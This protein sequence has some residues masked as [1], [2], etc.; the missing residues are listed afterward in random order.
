M[1]ALLGRYSERSF[2]GDEVIDTHW[3]YKKLRKKVLDERSDKRWAS[4]D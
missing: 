2:L 1:R 3:F 4:Y